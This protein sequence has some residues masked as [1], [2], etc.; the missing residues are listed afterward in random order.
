MLFE[1]ML[2]NCMPE[3]TQRTFKV[4]VLPTADL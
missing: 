4:N 1:Q 2:V 3:R